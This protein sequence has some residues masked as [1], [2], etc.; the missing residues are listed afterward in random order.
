MY[1][2]IWSVSINLLEMKK[3]VTIETTEIYEKHKK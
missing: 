1:G 3:L 2:L